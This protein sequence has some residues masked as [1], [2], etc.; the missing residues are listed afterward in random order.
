MKK[1][2]FTIDNAD[3]IASKHMFCAYTVQFFLPTGRSELNM[4]SPFRR[5]SKTTNIEETLCILFSQHKPGEFKAHKSLAVRHL[6]MF[7]R[8]I[9]I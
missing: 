8:G 1:P 7:N 2:H 9:N 4:V 5:V 6:I 3:R